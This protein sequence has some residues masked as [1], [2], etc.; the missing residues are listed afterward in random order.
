VTEEGLVCV[1]FDIPSVWSRVVELFKQGKYSQFPEEYK[2]IYFP[3]INPLTGSTSHFYKII[4]KEEGAFLW[5]E[6]KYDLK[7]PREQE[8]WSKPRCHQEIFRYNNKESKLCWM[9]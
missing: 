5:L 9:N 2:R 7:I 1:V 6:Q 4:N 8:A 3:K